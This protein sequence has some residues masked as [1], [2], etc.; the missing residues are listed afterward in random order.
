LL[1]QMREAALLAPVPALWGERQ[2]RAE[3][4]GSA[5]SAARL[6]AGPG[7]IGADGGSWAPRPRYEVFLRSPPTASPARGDGLTRPPGPPPPGPGRIYRRRRCRWR[8][9]P[10]V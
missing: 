4:G 7:L 9:Q 1:W 2:Q 10:L 8:D 5:R 6:R 3:A